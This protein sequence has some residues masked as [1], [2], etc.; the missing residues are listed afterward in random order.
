MQT[1]VRRDFVSVADLEE[2]ALVGQANH[3][4][5]VFRRANNWRPETVAGS[6]ASLAL[7]SLQFALP[8]TAVYEGI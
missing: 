2:Y 7:N 1:A 4:A 8:L 5:T 6:D 3:E